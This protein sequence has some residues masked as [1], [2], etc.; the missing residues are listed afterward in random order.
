MKKYTVT[1]ENIDLNLL[2][3]QKIDL[4][5]SMDDL[6][7]DAVEADKA[8]YPELSKRYNSQIE[9]LTGILN[10]LDTIQDKIE[11]ND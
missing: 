9:S 4:L 5:Q 10:L 1:I 6:C 8:G 2:K 7:C 3:D 11:D